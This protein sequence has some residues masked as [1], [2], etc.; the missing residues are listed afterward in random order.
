MARKEG[1]FLRGALG[2]LVLKEVRGKQIV[3]T[4]ARTKKSRLSKDTIRT[5]NVF[6]TASQIGTNIR[7]GLSGI[8]T[9]NY[10]GLMVSRMA[11]AVQDC[12]LPAQNLETEELEF[13][14]DTFSGLAGFEFN[15]SSPMKKNFFVKP[16]VSLTDS[17]LK[18]ALPEFVV[19]RE[20]RFPEDISNCKMLISVLMLDLVNRRMELCT[21]QILELRYDYP[22][23]TIPPHTFE[24]EVEPGCFCIAAFSLQYT[25]TTFAGTFLINTKT[26]N[27]AAI[28]F[29]QRAEGEIDPE[30]TAEWVDIRM[31]KTR[32]TKK[33]K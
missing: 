14:P 22:S 8:I 5:S 32:K 15:T 21:P 26:F 6:A 17:L 9:A 7:N 11:G 24:F 3:T 23:A 31:E 30:R 19:P 13:K 25:E 18:V 10:D 2:P 29:A 4:K 33:K 16:V 27:P 20:L 12:L 28:L 1:D